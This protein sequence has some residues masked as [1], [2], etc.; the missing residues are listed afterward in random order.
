MLLSKRE[1]DGK[2]QHP[3]PFELICAF[4]DWKTQYLY[5]QD[6]EYIT[7][8]IWILLGNKQKILLLV[9]TPMFNAL[10]LHVSAF[11]A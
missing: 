4:V 5:P 11:E 10:F 1:N 6:I 3:L 8:F 9:F 7:F 2:C